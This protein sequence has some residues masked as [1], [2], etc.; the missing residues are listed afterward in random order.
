M[1]ILGRMEGDVFTRWNQTQVERY[2]L[3]DRDSSITVVRRSDQAKSA[4]FGLDIVT[5][6]FVAGLQTSPLGY[7]PNLQQMNDLLLGRIEFTV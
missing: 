1:T 2:V 6:L 7:D 4:F 3:V 5:F